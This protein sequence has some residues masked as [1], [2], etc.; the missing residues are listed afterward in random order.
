MNK[1]LTLRYKQNYYESN[2]IIKLHALYKE[3]IIVRIKYEQTQEIIFC[4]G[5][6]LFDRRAVIA[7][8]TFK[9]RT[10]FYLKKRLN[11]ETKLKV[12]LQIST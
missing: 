12:V 9:F 11:Y 10:Y 7:K 4:H 6:I 8:K 3:V 1:Q 2:V 5:K